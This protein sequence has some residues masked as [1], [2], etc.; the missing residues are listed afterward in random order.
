MFLKEHHKKKFLELPLKKIFC[1]ENGEKEGKEEEEEEERKN[2]LACSE[3]QKKKIDKKKEKWKKEKE[4]RREW[5]VGERRKVWLDKTSG[6]QQ[7]VFIY[8]NVMETQF[9]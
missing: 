4:K 6:S 2:G 1:D 7:C 5:P 8:Q 9:S 3:E